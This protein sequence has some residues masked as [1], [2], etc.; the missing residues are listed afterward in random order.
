MFS[1]DYPEKLRNLL[2]AKLPHAG[3]DEVDKITDQF[4]LLGSFIVRV[5]LR[6]HSKPKELGSSKEIEEK[7][8]DPP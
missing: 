5:W 1:K 6:K 8:R 3:E 7:T 4:A 2:K